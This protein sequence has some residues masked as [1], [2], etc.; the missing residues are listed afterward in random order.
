MMEYTLIPLVVVQRF[1][2]F[3]IFFLDISTNNLAPTAPMQNASR[4]RSHGDVRFSDFPTITPSDYSHARGSK[5]SSKTSKYVWTR[6][7]L[8]IP[9]CAPQSPPC[10]DHSTFFRALPLAYILLCSISV[11]ESPSLLHTSIPKIA[12]TIEQ[13]PPEPPKK[14]HVYP[15]HRQPAQG[16]RREQ[17]RVASKPCLQRARESVPALLHPAITAER[18]LLDVL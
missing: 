1:N 16:R 3:R 5:K 11:D 4:N 8:A 17:G 7:V 9:T 12:T 10:D 2:R 14:T 13:K 6:L 18:A 15:R